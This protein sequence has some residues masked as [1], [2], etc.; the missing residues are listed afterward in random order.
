LG[1][2]KQEKWIHENKS[3]LNVKVCI[4]VGGTL[5]VFAGK[6]KL[7]PEFFRKNGLEWLYRLYREPRRFIRM[8]DLPLF[9]L[10]A[11]WTRLKKK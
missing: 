10:L 11:L 8:L 7:A 3:K 6:V 2:P 5:D 9:I 1:A 4:G